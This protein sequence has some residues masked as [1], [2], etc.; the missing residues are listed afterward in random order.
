MVRQGFLVQGGRDGAQVRGQF[1]FRVEE[2]SKQCR[3][4]GLGGR[5]FR[6]WAEGITM[7]GGYE[8]SDAG[9]LHG[10]YLSGALD[11]VPDLG[12]G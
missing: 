10:G 1:L 12:V 6:R 4:N 5:D 3:R 8:V 2:L 9:H 7:R 11:E